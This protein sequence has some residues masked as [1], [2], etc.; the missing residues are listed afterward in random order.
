MNDK[1]IERMV[2]IMNAKAE[3]FKAYIAKNNLTNFKVEEIIANEAD[4]SEKINFHTY[5]KIF[6]QKL[7][8]VIAIDESIYTI[9]RVQVIPDI[10]Y[11]KNKEEFIRCVNEMNISYKAVKYYLGADNA[12]YLDMYIPNKHEDI[13]GDLV[14]DLITAITS[15]LEK[16]YPNWMK[17]LWN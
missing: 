3:K 7:P 10:E 14:M 15:H 11:M 12:L 16:E 4:K 17:L 1:F 5:V 6:G 13:D 8:V 9:I 2:K